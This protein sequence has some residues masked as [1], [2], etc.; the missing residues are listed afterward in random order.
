VRI[1]DNDNCTTTS[2][3]IITTSGIEVIVLGEQII[4]E[5]TSVASTSEAFIYFYPKYNKRKIYSYKVKAEYSNCETLISESREAQRGRL[6]YEWIENRKFK[7][8]VRL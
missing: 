7:H 5:Y 2:N 1:L 6:I 3:S 4:S 8:Q